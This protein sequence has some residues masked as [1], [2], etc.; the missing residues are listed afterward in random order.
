M[1]DRKAA[2]VNLSLVGL[3]LVWANAFTFVRIA[4]RSLTPA[5][6]AILRFALVWP[7]LFLFPGLYRLRKLER[8][9]WSRLLLVSF[10]MVVGYHLALNAAETRVT[11]SVAALTAGFAPILTG[12]LSALFLHERL[13]GRRVAGLVVSL[14]GL[15]VLVLG[16]N[17]RIELTSLLGVFLAFLAPLCWSLSTVLSKP[18]VTRYRGLDVTVWGLF[19]GTLFLLPWLRPASLVSQVMTMP[20]IAWASVAYLAYLSILLGYPVW[21]HALETKKASETGMF[22]YLNPLIGTAS[23]VL[24]LHESLTPLMM[25]GAAG[26][27]AGLV[28]A[29]PLADR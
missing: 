1:R 19:L 5:N 27:L 14:A 21:F 20:F 24:F 15:V 12:V 9:D 7:F 23:G 13:P 17:G 25:L 10:L 2:L 22:V 16:I 11:A 6:L 3:F 8:R 26:I 18:L 28:I 4:T 29:N